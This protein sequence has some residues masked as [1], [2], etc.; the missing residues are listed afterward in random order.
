[1]T[2]WISVKDRLPID[3]GLVLGLRIDY[4]CPKC[5]I[6]EYDNDSKTWWLEHIGYIEISHWMPLPLPPSEK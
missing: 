2:E 3:G 6:T 1:M 5:V 4:Y